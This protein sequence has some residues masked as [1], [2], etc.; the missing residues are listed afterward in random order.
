MNNISD[1]VV[2]G[3]GNE[4]RKDDG[5]GLYVSRLIQERADREIKVVDGVPDGYA[6]IETWGDSNRV[7]IIDCVTSGAKAGTIY[8]FDALNEKIPGDLFDGFSTHSISVVDAIE[9][10]GTLGRLP[11]SLLIYGIEGRNFS[12]GTELSPEIKQAA[13]QLVVQI[14]KELKLSIKKIKK[15]G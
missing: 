1:V 4:F 11:K 13:D 2:V 12:L 8:R 9:L 15:G 5:V 3:I 7:I 6:L 10:A 14:L